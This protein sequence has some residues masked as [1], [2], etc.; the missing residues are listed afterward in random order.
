[1]YFFGFPMIGQPSD[2]IETT[3]STKL[4]AR[5]MANMFPLLTMKSVYPSNVRTAQENS[6]ALKTVS[7]SLASQA[8]TGYSYRNLAVLS[9]AFCTVFFNPV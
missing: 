1:M 9:Q 7:T 2:T 8:L 5:L 3:G 4:A 6:Y